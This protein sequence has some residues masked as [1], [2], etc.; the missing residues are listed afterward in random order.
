MSDITIFDYSGGTVPT[1]ILAR[2]GRMELIE[3]NT[4]IRLDLHDGEIHVVPGTAAARKYRRGRFELHTL[5]LRNAGA[6]FQRADRDSRSDREMNVTMMLEEIGRLDE[7]RDKRVV[8]LEEKARE[9]GFTS[10]DAYVD[11][12]GPPRPVPGLLGWFGRLTR[13]SPAVA[14]SARGIRVR[15]TLLSDLNE[16]EGLERRM[17][18]FRV[19]IQ[20]KFSI[21]FACVVF[22]LVGAPLGIR[23]RKGGFA[24]MAIAVAI[25]VLYYLFLI[26][27]EQL[28]DRRIVP[29]AVAMWLPNV[30]FGVLGLW[31]T[32]SVTGWGR[33]RGMR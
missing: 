14:D 23:T 24:N 5:V 1:T 10:Y 18:A 31:L 29:P 11:E 26:G 30:V 32:A 6:V 2:S 25:F 8:R 4:G 15:D 7:Q 3:Q 27:G 33:S 16:I 28:A 13:G 9:A 12:Y 22:V 17:N 21:P 20:K 19:E